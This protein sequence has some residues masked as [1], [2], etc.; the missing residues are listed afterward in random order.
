MK[1]IQNYKKQKINSYRQFLKTFRNTAKPLKIKTGNSYA[2]IAKYW[3]DSQFIDKSKDE[4]SNLILYYQRTKA[5]TI[6]NKQRRLL[7]SKVVMQNYENAVEDIG[8]KI[9]EIFDGEYDKTNWT[10]KEIGDIFFINDVAIKLDDMITIIKMNATKQQ[11]I[12][13]YNDIMNCR[14]INLRDWLKL[15][16]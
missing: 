5:K 6:K 10:N 15:N 4:K 14:K 12:Q 11:Y 3:L 7:C 16:K 8:K 1:L 2:S 13:Y 9:C